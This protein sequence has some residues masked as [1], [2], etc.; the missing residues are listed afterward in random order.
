MAGRPRKVRSIQSYIN[1]S[2]AHSGLGP[3]KAGTGNRVGIT[4]YLW[5][6]IQTQAKKGPR[7]FIN[8]PLYYQTLQFQTYGN[9]RPS[10]VASPR[11]GYTN[12]RIGSGSGS[13]FRP[14]QFNGNYNSN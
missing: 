8:N 9:L 4:N 7:D 6:N 1:N 5:Y 12:Y 11:Q 10:F 14:V 3:L 2:D 13:G